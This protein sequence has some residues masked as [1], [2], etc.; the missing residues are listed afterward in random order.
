MAP[1]AGRTAE[2]AL[3][4]ARRM[5]DQASASQ[6]KLVREGYFSAGVRFSFRE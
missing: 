2:E 4:A 1:T 6:V 3:A 5:W